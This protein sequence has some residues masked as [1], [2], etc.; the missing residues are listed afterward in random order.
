MSHISSTILLLISQ[1][2]VDFLSKFRSLAVNG[3][4]HLLSPFCMHSTSQHVQGCSIKKMNYA[5]QCGYAG[6]PVR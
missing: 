6:D 3:Q 4:Q 1:L 2:M 5:V